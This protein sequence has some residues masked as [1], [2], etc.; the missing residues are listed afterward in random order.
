MKIGNVEVD[1][2][3]YNRLVLSL[4]LVA[5]SEI[6]VLRE[7]IMIYLTENADGDILRIH[8]SYY[9]RYQMVSDDMRNL[10]YEKF[11]KLD[12]EDLFLPYRPQKPE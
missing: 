7:Y 4:L 1:E 12:L 6:T 11:G 2:Q 5:Q 10:I 8:K 3:E 9:E